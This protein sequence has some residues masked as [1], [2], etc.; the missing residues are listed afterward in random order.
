MRRMLALLAAGVLVLGLASPAAAAP[1]R[2]PRASHWEITCGTNPAFVVLAKGVPGW[3]TDTL[4]Y[5]NRPIL[6]MTGTINVYEGGVF[7]D[8]MTGHLAPGLADKVHGP[9][10]IVGPLEVPA[11]VYHLVMTDVYFHFPGD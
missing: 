3:Q 5:G 2:N 11:D 10:T 1:E 8:Q 6:W 7:V 4:E 9:C